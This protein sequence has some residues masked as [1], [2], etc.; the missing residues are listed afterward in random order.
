MTTIDRFAPAGL[1]AGIRS[2]LDRLAWVA[3]AL[4]PPLLRVALAVPFFR[5]GLTKWD[6]FLSLSVSAQY[7]FE[8][9]FKLHLFGGTYDFPMPDTIA[10]IDGL[11]EIVLPILLIV[12]LATRLSAVGLLAMTGVIQLVVP[13]GWANFHLPWAAMAVAIIALGPGRM[14]LDHLV[15]RI[16]EQFDHGAATARS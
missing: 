15:A 11:A 4:A 9:E 6:G 10:F 7:L 12:G 14:S 16:V 3:D 5:S 13:D 1:V 8:E 2:A